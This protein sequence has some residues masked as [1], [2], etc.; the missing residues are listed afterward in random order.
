MKIE[1]PLHSEIYELQRLLG[2][3]LYAVGGAIRDYMM[4]HFHGRNF[5]PKDIDVATPEHPSVV[6]DRVRNAGLKCL[7]IGASFGVV[8]AIMPSGNEYEIATFRKEWYD[9]ENGD[10]RRPDEVQFSTPE[11]DAQRRD[12]TINA[13]FYDL[14]QKVVHDHIGTG[15]EDCK[16]LVIRPVGDAKERYREDRLRV[17]RTIRFYHRYR[18]EGI[19]SHLP[20]E[21]LSAIEEWKHLPGVSGERIVAEFKS[22]LKQAIQARNFLES[23][24]ILGIAVFPEHDGPVIESRKLS[25]VFEQL[26]V[27]GLYKYLIGKK[28]DSA[29]AHKAQFLASLA[30]FKADDVYKQLK[31]RDRFSD[32]SL[33]SDVQEWLRVSNADCKLVERLMAFQPKTTAADFPKLQ[34]RELGEAIKEAI[35]Q[36]FVN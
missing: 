22:G 36:E 31:A 10:G 30:G 29:T 3:E 4:H 35:R 32:H 6:A 24:E 9:P 23:I 26:P 15:I 16:N 17:M 14:D 19:E 13:L 7:E 34:G 2:I 25:V 28:Y 12:L 27:E 1:I 21:T 11:A 5:D 18:N 20:A 8:V 33:K